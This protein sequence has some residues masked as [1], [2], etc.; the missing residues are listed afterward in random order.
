MERVSHLFHLFP[1][2]FLSPASPLKKPKGHQNDTSCPQ[3]LP[4][5]LARLVPLRRRVQS[6]VPIGGKAKTGSNKLIGK[7]CLVYRVALTLQRGLLH[8]HSLCPKNTKK[9]VSQAQT[10]ATASISS[11]MFTNPQKNNCHFFP[12]AD[13]ESLHFH[14]HPW[15]G[16]SRPSLYF[17]V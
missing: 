8:V 4:V 9:T 14:L 11:K 10:S 7:R 13:Q 2:V 16:G 17:S 5:S 6:R 15:C 12:M 1:D 3:P